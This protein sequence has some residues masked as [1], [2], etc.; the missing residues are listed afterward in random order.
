MVVRAAEAVKADLRIIL[1]RRDPIHIVHACS[2]GCGFKMGRITY[3]L[4]ACH[5]LTAQLNKLDRRFFSCFDYEAYPQITH[6]QSA[7]IG[8]DEEMIKRV[9]RVLELH[10]L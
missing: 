1:M 3:Y 9:M 2:E 10:I 4:D 7:H 6:E 8:Q 5:R